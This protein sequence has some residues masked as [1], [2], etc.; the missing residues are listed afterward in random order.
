MATEAEIDSVRAQIAT[1]T[2]DLGFECNSLLPDTLLGQVI[3]LIHAQEKEYQEQE[4][5]KIQK[6]AQ[7][8]AAEN[9]QSKI[10]KTNV[11]SKEDEKKAENFNVLD[12]AIIFVINHTL[13]VLTRIKGVFFEQNLFAHYFAGALTIALKNIYSDQDYNVITTVA[14]SLTALPSAKKHFIRTQKLKSRIQLICQYEVNVLTA[15]K[16]D[17]PVQQATVRYS[18]P[19]KPITLPKNTRDDLF[20]QQEQEQARINIKTAHTTAQKK[21]SSEIDPEIALIKASLIKQKSL[22]NEQNERIQPIIEGYKALESLTSI[23]NQFEQY[24]QK[25]LKAKWS[26]T[27]WLYACC[28]SNEDKDLTGHSNSLDK[29]DEPTVNRFKSLYTKY[30]QGLFFTDNFPDDLERRKQETKI[31]FTSLEAE[32][33]NLTRAPGITNQKLKEQWLYLSK[34]IAELDKERG[35]VWRNM[36]WKTYAQQCLEHQQAL[37]LE[38]FATEITDE[39]KKYAIKAV[40][41]YTNKEIATLNQDRSMM[42]RI[43]G[44]KSYDQQYLETQRRQLRQEQ[45]IVI[46][47][48]ETAV[49]ILTLIPKEECPA[50]PATTETAALIT[51]NPVTPKT[52]SVPPNA[53]CHTVES[54]KRVYYALRKSQMGPSFIKSNFLTKLAK[55]TDPNKQE[56]MI[57]DKANDDNQSRTATALAI[58]VQFTPSASTPFSLSSL[59]GGIH[60]KTG[61]WSSRLKANTIT[62]DDELK[63][64]YKNSRFGGRNRTRD[65][66]NALKSSQALRSA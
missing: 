63:I 49:D 57:R 24:Y 23:T 1:A 3:D 8:Q 6:R 55:E 18:D 11:N 65:I 28:Y 27:A 46:A 15:I 41:R 9:C 33:I 10:S 44:W 4:K 48:I 13:V 45:A 19:K 32:L 31:S 61:T 52:D 22:L 29:Y 64:L 34:N 54:F 21:F 17:I 7:V 59:V 50:A 25:E 14:K 16:F 35:M 53:S 20:S 2:A 30:Q 56:A 40:W 39:I 42:R 12:D 66:Y 37:L 43:M 60:G 51:S 26:I 36:G 38:N 58:A 5:K 62:D 47:D